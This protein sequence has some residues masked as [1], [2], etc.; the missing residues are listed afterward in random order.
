MPNKEGGSHPTPQMTATCDLA[1]R[2]CST[3]IPYA[4]KASSSNKEG[5]NNVSDGLEDGLVHHH[6]T[7]TMIGSLTHAEENVLSQTFL[8]PWDCEGGVGVC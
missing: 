8:S 3:S 7:I 6:A 5:A 2:Q 4:S 1:K